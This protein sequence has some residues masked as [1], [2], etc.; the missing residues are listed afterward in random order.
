MPGYASSPTSD[1]E[2]EECKPPQAKRKSTHHEVNKIISYLK[3]Q[4]RSTPKLDDLDHFFISACMSTKRLSRRIQ[5]KVKKDI[6]EI[7]ERAEE[8]EEMESK[9]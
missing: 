4:R 5:N 7:I 6:L 1:D 8:Q 3:E 9:P 2:D